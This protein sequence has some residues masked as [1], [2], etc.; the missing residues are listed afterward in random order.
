MSPNKGN[1]RN[2]KA[3]QAG[4]D[5]AGVKKKNDAGV[6]YPAPTDTSSVPMR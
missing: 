3:A 4:Q 5:K 6:S 1:I 2:R